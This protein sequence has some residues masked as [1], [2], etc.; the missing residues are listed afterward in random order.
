MNFCNLFHEV[1]FFFPSECK[2]IDHN[3]NNDKMKNVRQSAVMC[4]DLNEINFCYEMLLKF[5]ILFNDF[6]LYAS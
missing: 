4:Y 5:S 2:Y 1:I 3:S 6:V